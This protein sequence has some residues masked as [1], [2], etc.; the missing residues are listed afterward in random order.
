MVLHVPT[1]L[2][3]GDFYIQK[4]VSAFRTGQRILTPENAIL[5]EP[6]LWYEINLDAGARHAMDYLRKLSIGKT[7]RIE[8]F[9]SSKVSRD[10]STV[11]SKLMKKTKNLRRFLFAVSEFTI[12]G[13]A[14]GY[15]TLKRMSLDVLGNGQKMDWLVPTEIRHVD[16]YRIRKLS[17]DELKIK[18]QFYRLTER[19]WVDM[20]PNQVGGLCYFNN[21]GE[22]SRFTYGNGL[23]ESLYFTWYAKKICEG[24]MLNMAER[25]G[26]GGLLVA[27]IESLKQGSDAQSLENYKSNVL[28]LLKFAKSR[29]A[30]AI[31]K[32]DTI[33]NIPPGVGLDLLQGI[34]DY[35]DNKFLTL[36]LGANLSVESAQT[37]SYAQS[38]VH[39]GT[40][41]L[42]AEYNRGIISEG[43]TDCLFQLLWKHNRP[44]FQALG[45]A[46]GEPPTFEIQGQRDESPE[47]WLPILE[48]AHRLGMPI[49]KNQAY[50]LL[51]LDQPILDV[52]DEDEED[53]VLLPPLENV[54]SPVDPFVPIEEQDLLS[55]PR[56]E[57]DDQ[58]DERGGREELRTDGEPVS[59]A[60]DVGLG[61]PTLPEEQLMEFNERLG[62]F[63]KGLNEL[64]GFQ[65]Y[66]NL[67]NQRI[68]N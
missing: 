3:A 8:P 63:E 48:G 1:E 39:E 50:K 51:G 43:I 23:L 18:F 25:Y 57:Q 36:C 10:I 15:P 40:T 68:K 64:N 55:V 37:G 19:Q 44:Q 56:I 29:H 32:D 9:D 58:I 26:Q 52:G 34:I 11:F 49:V 41:F 7:H 46:D 17:D 4:L 59:S 53:E 12:R 24:E 22:E 2:R 13:E 47:K 16:R 27:Q 35:Y 65:R 66:Q 31:S 38:I 67:L 21:S 20:S 61:G 28:Q 30:I 60:K 33:T 6:E 62:E 45:L 42:N 5:Q 54:R 14:W